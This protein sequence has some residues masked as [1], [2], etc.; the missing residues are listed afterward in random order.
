MSER[1]NARFDEIGIRKRKGSFDAADTERREI[2]F[3]VL[4]VGMV[5]RVIG[6]EAVERAVA[7]PLSDRRQVLRLADGR[8][9]F[10]V[11]HRKK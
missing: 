7:K 3:H 4:F 2:V 10:R 9:D 5:R 11:R 1:K 8:V 6:H